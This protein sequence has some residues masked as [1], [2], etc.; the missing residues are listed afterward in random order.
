[1]LNKIAELEKMV[2]RKIVHHVNL[3]NHVTG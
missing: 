2:H 1:M 3:V